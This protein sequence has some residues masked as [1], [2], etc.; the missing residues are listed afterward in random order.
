VLV[1]M[2]QSTAVPPGPEHP[3]GSF[4]SFRLEDDGTLLRGEVP[5]HLPPKELAALRLLLAHPGRIVTPLQLRQALWG[6]VHV[7]ADSVPKCVS[8]LRARLGPDECIQTVY[9]RGYR[10]TAEVRIDGAG[11]SRALPRLA[12]LPFAGG[13]SVPDYLGSVIAEETMARLSAASPSA[14]AVLAQ[15][16]VFTLASRGMT[17]LEVG[18]ALDADLVLAG[19]LR[20]LPLHFRL[21]AEM[22]RVEDGIQ[23]W[24]EDALVERSRAAGLE[25]ELVNRLVF[26]LSSGAPAVK[27]LSEPSGSA[28]FDN[29]PLSAIESA[30]GLSIA[31]VA[32]A[33][34]PA[35]AE[36][37]EA[38]EIF[39][40][41]HHEWQTLERHRMQ[42]GLQHLLRATE[43]DPSLIAARVDLV[44]LCVAQGVYGFM[45]P[46]VAADIVRRTAELGAL[47]TDARHRGDKS[48]PDSATGAYSMLPALG[49]IRFHADRNLSAA[50]AAFSMS[51]HLP[52]DP[53]TTRVRFMFA[54]SLRRF[55]EAIKLL[56]DTIRL[57]PYSAWLHGRLAWALHL[58]GDAGASVDQINSA[59]RQFPDHAG[60]NLYG[61]VILAFNGEAA[62]ANELA[63]GFAQ[64]LPYFDLATEVH[65]YA[66]ACAGRGDEARAILERLQWLGRERFLLKAFTP[67]IYVTLGEPDAAIAELRASDEARC[68]WF[69]QMLADPRLKPLEDRPEFQQLC[70]LLPAMQAEATRN[71]EASA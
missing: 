18:R 59:L 63:E 64:R 33:K 62:R 71:P 69:F 68:P 10:F 58:A 22:I 19:T 30:E 50:L 28:A 7:T 36:Q 67:A 14:I 48:I 45:S 38:Y 9:K 54:L 40:R 1:R 35:G 41:A 16:S 3:G 61:S 17:A 6:D 55:D 29:A 46:S 32:E 21:R 8:S 27:P 60:T 13:F 39:Q 56:R 53:W 44:N 4:A 24:V 57:D 47:T 66:L 2:H 31:A 52:H 26:R 65:A 20:A 23:L 12:I 15:D 70:A 11:P 25:T 34:S 37:R 5:V 42:D 49:W 43:L 51:A